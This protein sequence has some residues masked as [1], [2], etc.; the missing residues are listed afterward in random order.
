MN[1]QVFV[2]AWPMVAYVD[3]GLPE[4]IAGAVV[5]ADGS[6]SLVQSPAKDS[7]LGSI[8]A[9]MNNMG[10][11]TL[12]APTALRNQSESLPSFVLAD[13]LGVFEARAGD[14]LRLV[15]TVQMPQGY[16][17]SEGAVSNLIFRRNE[18]IFANAEPFGRVPTRLM[19]HVLGV[20]GTRTIEVLG[21]SAAFSPPQII[22][23]GNGLLLVYLAMNPRAGKISIRAMAVPLGND[24][25]RATPIDL[26]TPV[27]S[28]FFEGPVVL[29]SLEGRST[30]IAW[31]H[32]SQKGAVLHRIIVNSDL[33]VRARQVIETHIVRPS[34]LLVPIV[35]S[36]A[37]RFFIASQDSA[38]TTVQLLALDDSK[39]TLTTLFTGET[40]DLPLLISTRASKVRLLLARRPRNG[41]LP[42][43]TTLRVVTRC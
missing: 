36:R 24:T 28:E 19:V 35:A 38:A 5:R 27:D 13:E 39:P 7:G 25:V 9:T 15:R 1:G 31:L 4:L 34:R 2:R 21:S 23:S 14:H 18:L 8:R 10:S 29:T 17:W 26:D 41:Q 37:S 6:A 3:R 12:V 11:V 32:P 20:H 33:A 43:L 16:R 40:I 42:R 30:S 22:E